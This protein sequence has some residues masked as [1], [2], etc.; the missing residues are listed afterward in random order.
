[1]EEDV[2]L[3]AP[4]EALGGLGR[5][6]CRED[7]FAELHRGL[8]SPRRSSTRVRS[9]FPLPII[10]REVCSRIAKPVLGCHEH[11]GDYLDDVIVGLN[12]M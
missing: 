2:N 7:D 12:S 1:M 4:W 5:A 11:V 3:A 9:L 8:L 10:P 6:L